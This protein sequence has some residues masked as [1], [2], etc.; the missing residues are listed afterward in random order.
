[1]S[2]A[3]FRRLDDAFNQLLEMGSGPRAELLRELEAESPELAARLRAMLRAADSDADP[4]R[5]SVDRAVQTLAPTLPARIGPFEVLRRL[6]EGGMGAVFLCQRGDGDF[7]QLVAVKRLGSAA[8]SDSVRQRLALERRL[9]ARLRHPH[10]AQFIDGGEDADGTPFVAMEYVEGQRIDRHAQEQSLDRPA[11][12]RLFQQLCSAV[13]FAHAN[14]I[15]HRDIKPDN[16]LVDRHGQVKLLDFGIAKL[17]GEDESAVESAPTMAGAMT[18]HY[19]SPEQVRGEPVSQASD[20]YSLGVLLYELLSGQRPYRIDS[21]RPSEIERIVCEQQPT[22]LSQRG[23]RRGGA[24]RDLDAILAKAMHKQ[25]ERR[26]DSA[27]QLSEDIARWLQGLPV[28][29]RP[30]SAGYRLRTWLRR[31]PFG[32]T[33]AVLSMVLLVGFAGA[34]AWQAE[35]VAQERDLAQREARI[36]QETADFL[37]EL[38][39]ASDPRVAGA[40][41]L[42]ARDLLAAGAERLPQ[43]LA[44]D[45]L[46]RARLLQVIGLAYANLG[47]DAPAT[48]LMTDAL[49]LREQH[50]GPDSADVAD[51]L[52]RLGDVHRRFGRLAEAETML[53]RALEWRMLNGPVDSDLADSHNN[54]GLIQNDLGHHAEAEATLRRAVDLHRQVAGPQTPAV[55]S[56][57]HNLALALRAQGRLEEARQAAVESVQRKREAGTAAASLANTL[58]VLANVERDMGRLDEALASS[59]ESLALRRGVFGDDNP[60]IVPGLVARAN[61]LAAMGRNGEARQHYEQAM[62]LHQQAGQGE[63]LGLA[64]SHLSYGRFL[65]RLSE[66]QEA[67]HHIE[68]AHR[69]ASDQLATGSPALERYAQALADVHRFTTQ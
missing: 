56:P 14:L 25:A 59:S 3:D 34:M 61:V 68:R 27:A 39:G 46:A 20:I 41:D 65:L 15:V 32:A 8:G 38:F 69:I 42:R 50:A 19:A 10:I 29:A 63:T 24:A 1:M 7:I 40:G 66:L 37:I 6:G 44:S 31:H 47:D 43:A 55:V 62:T 23:G 9:L 2:E 53:V 22:P 16:V 51:S 28:L 49:R 17:L 5:V 67:Q 52:N 12:L 36:S 11:R 45:P 35:R 33:V 21:T 18:P 58:G 4:L 60:M 30:D 57:L 54:V 48:A 26:Y 64:N 13:Q